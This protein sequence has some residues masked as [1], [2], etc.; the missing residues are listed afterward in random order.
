MRNSFRGG[1]YV[2]VDLV[3]GPGVDVVGSGHEIKVGVGMFD[4]VLACECFEHNP[5]WRETLA[6]MLE[7]LRPNGMFIVTSAA[8]G[9]PEHGTPRSQPLHSLSTQLSWNYYRNISERELTQVVT[10][11]A[12]RSVFRTFYL[13]SEADLYLIGFV[14]TVSPRLNDRLARLKPIW[15]SDKSKVLRAFLV[16]SG[17]LETHLFFS[18]YIAFR[19]LGA[20]QRVYLAL[21]TLIP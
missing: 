9:R 10:G 12:R 15:E 14:D 7:H 6:N 1:S 8:P 3:P 16:I 19:C 4:L 2:G 17:I 21:K 11:L 18:P 13:R 20:L 5:Y